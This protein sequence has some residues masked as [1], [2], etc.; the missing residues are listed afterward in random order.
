MSK[1]TK[2]RVTE[3]VDFHLENGNSAIADFSGG[4]ISGLGG[5]RSLKKDRSPLSHLVF[6]EYLQSLWY[7]L[8]FI[9]I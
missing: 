9:V 5:T 4:D 1:S 7:L 2:S 8:A 6:T 3:Q